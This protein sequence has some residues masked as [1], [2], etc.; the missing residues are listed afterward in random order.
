LLP[1]LAARP[2]RNVTFTTPPPIFFDGPPAPGASCFPS[3]I[4]ERGAKNCLRFDQVF[5]NVGEGPMELRFALP[6]DPTSTAHNVYQRVHWSDGTFTDRPA[7]E[8]EYHVTHQHYHYL[9]F[10]MSRL[11]RSNEEGEQLGTQPVRSSQKIGFCLA[12]VEIDGWL[13]KSTGVRRYNAPDCIFPDPTQS[14]ANFNYLVQGIT[15]GWAD[16]YEWY[17]PDQYI[18]VTGV[19][20]GYYLLETIANP[21]NLLL[22][23]NYTNNSGSVL[24]R[25]RHMG[26]PLQSAELL[27]PVDDAPPPAAGSPQSKGAN[28]GQLALDPSPSSL[29][30]AS[31]AL[32]ALQSQNAGSMVFPVTPLGG[33]NGLLAAPAS[34]PSSAPTFLLAPVDSSTDTPHGTSSANLDLRPVKALVNS[35]DAGRAQD[36][37][38]NDATPVV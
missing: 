19:P 34:V 26:T 31:V 32:F 25:L 21:D 14:D 6:K 33:G 24:I 7:G 38:W 10:A 22:E 3:E 11:W 2:Q 15:P 1:D 20:D 18:E 37:L 5:A 4:Q 8:W 30:Q 35:I 13:K 23:S 27:G 28:Q 9:D 17:L 29:E 36:A 16:V 12:D